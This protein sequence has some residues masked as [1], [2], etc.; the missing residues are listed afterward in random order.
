ML[1]AGA[2][3]DVGILEVGAMLDDEGL[4]DNVGVVPDDER[5]A[6]EDMVL[7]DAVGLVLGDDRIA[8]PAD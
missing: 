7:D 6:L 4:T 1:E 5:V 2:L 3:D 8:L